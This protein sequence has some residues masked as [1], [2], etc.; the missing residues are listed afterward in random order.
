MERL[1]TARRIEDD[2]EMSR[3]WRHEGRWSLFGVDLQSRSVG[4]NDKK[5]R[6]TKTAPDS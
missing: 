4:T 5:H 6:I 2:A 3:E 1:K